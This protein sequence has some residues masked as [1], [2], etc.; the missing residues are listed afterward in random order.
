MQHSSL[1]GSTTTSSTFT[2]KLFTKY[3]A[4]FFMA[5]V[6]YTDQMI[7]RLESFILAFDLCPPASEINVIQLCQM[8]TLLVNKSLHG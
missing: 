3:L 7:M 2:F 1:T 5:A 8:N 4:V 6:T